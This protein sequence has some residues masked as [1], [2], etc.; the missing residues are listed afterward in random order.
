MSAKHNPLETLAH[1]LTAAVVLLKGFDKATHF[2]EHPVTAS[3]L[4]LLGTLILVA[5]IFHRYFTKH[6]KDFRII[7]H[8]FEFFVLIIVAYYYF[9]EGKRALPS[10][11]VIA[12][13]GHAIS[14]WFFYRKKTTA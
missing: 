6:F 8:T 10:V 1:Y 3:L 11:Y 4:I 14:A 13:I 7:L 2:N 12:A 5:T 9:S